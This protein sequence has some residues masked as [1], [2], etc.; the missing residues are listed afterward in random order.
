MFSLSAGECVFS[1]S[2]G[3]REI[4]H[5]PGGRVRAVGAT[6]SEA[7]NLPGAFLRVKVSGSERLGI[8]L[9]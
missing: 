3:R 1:L 9:Q 8:N 4:R 6:V 5:M 7:R 2:G